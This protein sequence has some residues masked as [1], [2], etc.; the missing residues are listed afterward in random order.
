MC[1]SVSN[2]GICFS[3]R[4]SLSN[5]QMSEHEVCAQAT[6]KPK[7]LAVCCEAVR[8]DYSEKL[9][10]EEGLI[11][12]RLR[13]REPVTQHTG[14]HA[15]C[16]VPIVPVGVCDAGVKGGFVQYSLNSQFFK[17][18]TTLSCRDTHSTRSRNSSTDR[19]E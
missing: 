11:V 19:N 4:G 17:N 12:K 14:L 9:V 18:S 15:C 13:V 5:D 8:Y 7:K 1:N 6:Q 3:G 2:Q 10:T 16:F